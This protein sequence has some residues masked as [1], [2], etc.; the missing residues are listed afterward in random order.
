MEGEMVQGR[1]ILVTGATGT[2]ARPVAE[3]LVKDNEVWCAARFSDPKAKAELESQGIKT[4]LWDMGSGDFSALP[5]DFDHVLHSAFYFEPDLAQQNH[6]K[7]ISMNA[8]ATALLM[9]HCRKARSFVFVSTFCVYRRQHEPYSHFYAETDPLGTSVTFSTSYPASKIA[10]EGAVRATA[11]LLGLPTTIARMNVGH[12]GKGGTGGLPLTFHRI[13]A[14]GQ[15]VPIPAGPDEYCSPIGARD[16]AAQ[17]H[18]LFEIAS[19]PTTIVNW[20]GDEAVTTRELCDYI[21]RITGV[22]AAFRESPVWFDFYPSDNTRREQLVGKCS[23]GWKDAVR[24]TIE[25]R[26]ALGSN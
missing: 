4:C 14:A 20:A 5:D 15:P 25:S 16:I 11:R 10:A 26:L 6:D 21:A 12:G 1:K 23:V 13:M 22:T 19:I 9:W 8:E 17:S 18:A 3:H 7:A 2:I 24:E